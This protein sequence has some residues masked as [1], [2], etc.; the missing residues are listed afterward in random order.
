MR[1]T[2]DLEGFRASGREH[3]V[4]PV[5]TTVLADSETPLSI[6]RRIAHG[7][8]GGF[9]LESAQH[10][11]WSRYSFIGRNPVAT[12]TA[13]AGGELVWLGTV[14]TGA[15]TSG[16]PVA[17][18]DELLR[19]L[20]SEP[21]PD[22]PPMISSLVGYL[23]WDAV[24]RFERLGPGPAADAPMPLLSLSIPGDVVIFDHY[25]SELTLVANVINVDGL[26]TGIEAAHAGGVERLHGLLD[27]LRAP[28][29]ASISQ[30]SPADPVVTTTTTHADYLDSVREAQ[31]RIV[32]GDIFQVV[33]GQRFTT[34]CPADPLEVYRALRRT[35][36]SPYMYLMDIP[37]PDGPS[38]AV[39]GSSPEALVTVA[40]GLLSTHPIAGSRPRG[41]T[42]AQDAALA[43]ELLADEK[44]R[45]EHLM[46]VDLARN[47]LSK[48]CAAGSV[49]VTQFME[50]ER[51]SHI[52]HISSTVTGRLREGLTG[53]DV[54]RATFPAGTLSG[55]PK[56]MALQIIDELEPVARGLYGGVVGYLSFSGNLDMAIAIRTGVIRQ[57]LVHVYAG[58]GVVA[59]S[60]PQAEYEESQNKAAAVLRAAAAA[61]GLQEDV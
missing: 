60:V 2:P 43:A 52:M 28:L 4:V 11:A 56:P 6:Y 19:V 29:P 7:R 22:L 13:D 45:A 12:L 49:D 54:L 21:H 34:E 3:R 44:E 18:A 23:G 55:A 46:L 41:A 10:G 35:N 48:V 50:I 17:A 37:V 40:D 36:P 30:W 31:R 8:P 51:F 25:T 58:G 61:A 57:G 59:D 38:L 53:I 27:D 47:D 5:Y 39:V 33:I 32:D 14:P 26:D 16:D 42:G 15:P 1:I 24:R 20:R 9:L